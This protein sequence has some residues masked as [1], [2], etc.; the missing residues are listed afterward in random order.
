MPASV[1]LPPV[2]SS[3]PTEELGLGVR[4]GNY[5]LVRRVGLGGMGEVYEARHVHLKKRVAIKRLH[6]CFTWNREMKRRFLREGIAACQS[7][8]PNIVNITDMGVHGEIPYLVMEF[9]DGES[10]E[11]RI[12]RDGRLAIEEVVRLLLPVANALAW[13]HERGVIHRDVKPANIILARSRDHVEVKLVDF[14]ISRLEGGADLTRFNHV[15]GTLVY[16]AP[17]LRAGETRGDALT[18]QFALGVTL[19]ETV[20]GE[21]P[22]NVGT[23]GRTISLRALRPD[24]PPALERTILRAMHPDRSK[25]FADLH[26]LEQA[27]RAVRE[28][29][30]R[31]QAPRSKACHRSIQLL[32]LLLISLVVGLLA[33]VAW[34]WTE[35]YGTGTAEPVTRPLSWRQPSSGPVSQPL[36][37]LR[38]V[39]Y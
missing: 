24:V 9:L 4:I 30:P 1:A 14:G 11:Q 19:F 7:G 26:Q 38:S 39:P 15:L 23:S 13:A 21:P 27:L 18:D 25:R 2:L 5:E 29:P 17:E 33:M 35:S 28:R 6:D 20:A 8:H 16:M 36:P 22:R 31:A 10:L 12:H 37:A 34:C 3:E 32:F